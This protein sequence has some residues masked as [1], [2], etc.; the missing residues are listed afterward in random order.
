MSV[1]VQPRTLQG[2]RD[3]LPARA[4]LKNW[5]IGELRHTFELFGFEPLETPAL[6][7]ADVLKAKSGD[8]ADKLLYEFD[9]HGGRR[10]GL[11]YD[12][13]IPLARVVAT[14]PELPRPFKRYHIDSVWRAE[15]PQKGRYR[16]FTQCDVDVVG[17][18]SPLADAEV[19]T[20][21]ATGLT[22]LGFEQ[23]R[24]RINSRK[25]LGA[26]AANLGV[27]GGAIPALFRTI[28][29]L[30]KIGWEGVLAELRERGFEERLGGELRALFA[31]ASSLDALVDR[32]ADQPLAVE[33]IG[34]LREIIA[35][36]GAAGVGEERYRFD[37]SLTR[38]LDYYTG[39][40][41]EVE[42][43]QP[44]IGALAGGGRYDNL[45]GIFLGKPVPA[46]GVAF[47]FDRIID[48]ID[49]LGLQPEGAGGTV[50]Q[51]FVTVFGPETT[52]ASLSLASDLR[53]AGVRTELALTGDRIGNQLRAAARRAVPFVAI[54][55]PDEL[56][57]DEVV[58]KDMG[59]GE[60]STVARREVV[61]AVA[62]RLAERSR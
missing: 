16:Q 39:P 44:K 27:P 17:T 2:M 40:V 11:R 29:K 3:W 18:T 55:G 24:I 56:A 42:V 51:V 7:Y 12:L 45:I 23:F 50:A 6:E 28:D 37:L 36:L 4:R 8:E 22:R 33:G 26:V 1:T 48:V 5:V 20:V 62:A 49:E 54:V 61:Q 52:M 32:L 34:E 15:R 57:R 47:G 14:Y 19:L 35:A 58:L 25:V 21:V 30:D 59:S 9:D 41:F 10:I 31:E 38:G 60:Q 53:N 43:E 46:T 13:T